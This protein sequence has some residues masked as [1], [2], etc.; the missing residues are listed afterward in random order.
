ME[1]LVLTAAQQYCVNAFKKESTAIMIFP[2]C[3]IFCKIQVINQNDFFCVMY[4]GSNGTQ[5]IPLNQLQ[6]IQIYSG[7]N[8]TSSPVLI[9]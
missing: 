2:G 4:R 1:K 6:S 7:I 3:T 8:F 9:F 5:L